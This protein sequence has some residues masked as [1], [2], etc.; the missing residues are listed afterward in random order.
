MKAKPFGI[1]WKMHG[2]YC[3][4]CRKVTKQYLNDDETHTCNECLPRNRK[5]VI[6]QAFQLSFNF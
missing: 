1:G 2:V 3:Y 4:E 5:Y 6:K